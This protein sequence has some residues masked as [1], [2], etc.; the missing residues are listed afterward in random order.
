MFY[1]PCPGNA[2]SELWLSYT[3]VWEVT[4]RFLTGKSK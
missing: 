2:C 3:V 1:L 4:A